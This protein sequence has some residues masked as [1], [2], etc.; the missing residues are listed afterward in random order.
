M[1]MSKEP[2]PK[3]GEDLDPELLW[4]K[5]HRDAKRDRA[6]SRD[7]ENRERERRELIEGL[8]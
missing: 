1:T 2:E 6:A 4:Q 7:R 5:R 8:L 3:P